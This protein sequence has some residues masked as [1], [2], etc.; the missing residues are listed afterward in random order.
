MH[1]A[2]VQVRALTGE[3]SPGPVTVAQLTEP[4][5]QGDEDY[6]TSS[7]ATGLVLT[8]DTVENPEN[9]YWSSRKE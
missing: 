3:S 8:L 9:G 5:S 6:G 2:H 7:K 1:L 4:G